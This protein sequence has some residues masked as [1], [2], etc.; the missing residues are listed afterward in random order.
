MLSERKVTKISAVLS[1]HE[2]LQHDESRS[3]TLLHHPGAA[4]RGARSGHAAVCRNPVPLVSPEGGSL[5]HNLVL[6]IPQHSVAALHLNDIGRL[7]SFQ[8]ITPEMYEIM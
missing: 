2:G 5:L 8:K 4:E 7:H 1:A 3:G 6:R